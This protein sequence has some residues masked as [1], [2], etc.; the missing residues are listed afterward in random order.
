M[1]QSERDVLM[2]SLEEA[3]EEVNE[4]APMSRA[5]VISVVEE[6]VSKLEIKIEDINRSLSNAGLDNTVDPHG[7]R[8]QGTVKLLKN[9]SDDISKLKERIGNIEKRCPDDIPFVKTA[10]RS[11]LES[12]SIPSISCG[13]FNLGIC[14][15][16]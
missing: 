7:K 10:R 6:E 12:S 4:T 8:I 11:S 9:V 16:H 5:K 15:K 13:D 1:S 3:Q 14:V 2:A